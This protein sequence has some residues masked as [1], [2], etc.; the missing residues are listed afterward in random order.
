MKESGQYWKQTDSNK[1]QKVNNKTNFAFEGFL[2][3]LHIIAA[4]GFDKTKD[5]IIKRMNMLYKHVYEVMNKENK[6]PTNLTKPKSS[7]IESKDSRSRRIVKDGSDLYI[8]SNRSGASTKSSR[9]KKHS[10]QSRKS[11]KRRS[12]QRK[13]GGKYND[14]Y[15]PGS[16]NN[17]MFKATINDSKNSLPALSAIYGSAFHNYNKFGRRNNSGLA[18][19]DTTNHK[20]N[21]PINIEKV[22]Q[23]LD[24]QMYEKNN[25]FSLVGP[26]RIPSDFRDSS[27]KKSSAYGKR[28]SSMTN[29]KTFDERK[30]SD[31]KTMNPLDFDARMNLLKQSDLAK[32]EGLRKHRYKLQS[33]IQEKRR[34]GSRKKSSNSKKRAQRKISHH[35]KNQFAIDKSFKA[36]HQERNKQLQIKSKLAKKLNGVSSADDYKDTDEA[37][38]GFDNDD[39]QSNEYNIDNILDSEHINEDNKYDEKEELISNNPE[40]CKHTIFSGEG[41]ILGTAGETTNHPY[42]N[43]ESMDKTKKMTSTDII[44]HLQNENTILKTQMKKMLKAFVKFRHNTSIGIDQENIKLSNK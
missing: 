19:I 16:L 18:A 41:E 36:K 1:E 42:E 3:A 11:K 14:R 21:K 26:A 13:R 24:V 5:D 20:K 37:F 44:N 25:S 28:N 30:S 17:S 2:Q 31:F 10:S 6:T 8:T 9:A 34:S 22:N 27:S 15:T 7:L 23:T 4:N 38:N 29:Q 35:Y 32:Y 12:S 40:D 39:H 33:L 43:N